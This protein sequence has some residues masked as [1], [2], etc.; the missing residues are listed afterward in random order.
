MS[1]INVNPEI[2]SKLIKVMSNSGIYS[3]TGKTEEEMLNDIYN[4]IN[5]DENNTKYENTEKTRKDIMLSTLKEQLEDCIDKN[6]HPVFQHYCVLVTEQ[7][8]YRV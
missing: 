8:E 4:R 3:G 5:S 7:K 1:Q 6:G 2:M